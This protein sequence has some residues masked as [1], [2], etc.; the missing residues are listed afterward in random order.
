MVI[1]GRSSPYQDPASG[2]VRRM[3]RAYSPV[4]GMGKSFC[5]SS[6]RFGWLA[7]TMPRVWVAS[8]WPVSSGVP[9][10]EQYLASSAL[11]WRQWLQ[12]VKS[13]PLHYQLPVTPKNP[14]SL[15]N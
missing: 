10:E 13:N 15:L 1:T 14:L 8:S 9:Q 7:S 4:G 12:T 5:V 11:E 6:P 3:R 2:P